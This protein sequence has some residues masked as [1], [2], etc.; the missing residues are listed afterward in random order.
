VIRPPRFDSRLAEIAAR[1]GAAGL[2]DQ[3]RVI[4]EKP[5]GRDLAGVAKLQ[6]MPMVRTRL[7]G[8]VGSPPQSGLYPVNRE[9]FREI[10][11]D[12]RGDWAFHL[13]ATA[14]LDSDF[15]LPGRLALLQGQGMQTQR[16]GKQKRRAQKD[17]CY[18]LRLQPGFDGMS[19]PAR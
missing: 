19:G 18:C 6:E 10:A 11:P 3:A 16:T 14:D 15:A 17:C 12:L 1:L 4:V 8:G 7:L 5:F 13:C 9:K 2:A